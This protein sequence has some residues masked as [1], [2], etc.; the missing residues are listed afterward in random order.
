M[1]DV[2]AGTNSS[3]FL[4]ID[5]CA[6]PSAR[7][8]PTA[9]AAGLTGAARRARG[10]APPTC[11]PDRPH[12]RCGHAAT[13]PGPGRR[14]LHSQNC[15]SR[16]HPPTRA[17]C[18]RPKA[19][20][21]RW[22]RTPRRTGR[23]A[24]PPPRPA[25]RGWRSR[26]RLGDPV[27]SPRRSAPARLDRD[28]SSAQSSSSWWARKCLSAALP[29]RSARAS[30]TAPVSFVPIWAKAASISR[31]ERISVPSRSTTRGGAV[32]V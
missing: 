21:P 12:R 25:A 17:P 27:P 20:G 16:T 5:G 29:P 11:D 24:A 26:D 13:P 28:G 19:Y 6:A 1:C 9:V 15:R 30:S 18:R 10:C 14:C 2:S 32:S 7:Y 8:A 22:W 4:R 23:D 31:S 3:V